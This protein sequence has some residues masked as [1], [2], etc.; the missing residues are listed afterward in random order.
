MHPE[1]RPPLSVD[2][3]LRRLQE[4]QVLFPSAILLLHRLPPHHL[5]HAQN[6]LGGPDSGKA[7]QGDISPPLWTDPH[8]RPR[9]R[10]F[11]LLLLPH[12]PDVEGNDNYRIL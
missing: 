11:A 3:Q 7:L 6:S 1:T 4:S 10:A 8:Y 12:L 5:D 2:L 9:I